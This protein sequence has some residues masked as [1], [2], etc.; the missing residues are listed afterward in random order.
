M[1]GAIREAESTDIPDLVAMGERFFAASG[2]G[3]ITHFDQ[4]SAARTFDG[5]I[6]NPDG[7]ILIY[8]L[9][10]AAVATAAALSFPFFF[11]AHHRHAQE[12]FWW[13]DPD[14]RGES[15]P[16]LLCALEQWA[17]AIGA[18]SLALAA[19]A[20]MR[21]LAVGRLYERAGYRPSDATYVK[22]LN[23]ADW[24]NSSDTR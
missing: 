3:E 12:F 4:L 21:P 5:L 9:E 14:A 16:A 8:E 22:G 6:N 23:G 7:V 10:G 11:N 1:R 19:L 24:N 2:Y 18:Q 17:R 13:A 20:S 15:G